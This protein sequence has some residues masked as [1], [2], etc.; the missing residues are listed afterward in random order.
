MSLADCVRLARR[1]AEWIEEGLGIPAHLGGAAAPEGLSPP[2][3]RDRAGRRPRTAGATA[4]LAGDL[5][6]VL[7]VTIEE[8][9]GSVARAVADAVDERE[10]GLAG[11]RASA[12]AGPRR[13][14]AT[15]SLSLGDRRTSVARAF[16]EVERL[17][18]DRGARVRGSRLAGM[19]ARDAIERGFAEAA[20]CA[21]VA[22]LDPLP[23]FLDALAASDPVPAG[24]AAAAHA[25]A[26]GAALAAKAAAVL[27]RRQADGRLEEI[28]VRAHGLRRELEVLV[29]RDAQAYR[30]FLD[31]PSDA[32]I[33]EAVLVPVEIAE[34]AGETWEL[35]RELQK[36]AFP[37][38]AT[39]CRGAA[40]LADAALEQ[41]VET[42]HVN[43]VRVRDDAFAA[44]V[45]DRLA[46]IP[47]STAAETDY[48]A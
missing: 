17:A 4:V 35:A 14:A 27:Q 37:G 16:L 41:T 20:R 34:R 21:R 42:V 48:P 32:T 5:P 47:R 39:D 43:L 8:A 44:E 28:R 15:V 40:R 26:M 38:L 13:G 45:R 9:D 46:R 25:A 31:A 18:A 23:G 10:G 29:G 1:F 33:R 6:I 22:V 12:A 36:R 3:A 19:V 11:V 30:A 2:E 24:A 7:H